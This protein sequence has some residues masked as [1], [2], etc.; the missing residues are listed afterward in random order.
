MRIA[1]CLSAA[2]VSLAVWTAVQCQ[3][4]ELPPKVVAF[5]RAR[6]KWLLE[7]II[8]E[9]PPFQ[10]TKLQTRVRDAL[11]DEEALLAE[12]KAQ[13]EPVL[14]R[15]EK[16]K[17]KP[18]LAALVKKDEAR[19]REFKD[20]VQASEERV[21]KLREKLPAEE[22]QA[23][24]SAKVTEKRSPKASMRPLDF[25]ALEVGAI[26]LLPPWPVGHG[27]RQIA[28]L[29]SADVLRECAAKLTDGNAFP[30]AYSWGNLKRA[31][32]HFGGL[33]VARDECNV[34]VVQVLDQSRVFATFTGSEVPDSWP[35]FVLDVGDTTDLADGATL[36]VAGPVKV[37]EAERY[38]TVGGKSPI[39]YVLKP[40]ATYAE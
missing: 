18:S 13:L 33:G 15:I 6:D 38:A 20:A 11:R 37:V 21:A 8:A 24:P 26:G 17:G 22:E 36:R 40:L 25:D 12:N 19:A 9:S 32:D 10:L 31:I 14:R 29:P 28:Y 7:K 4:D 3:A 23:A 2:L 30:G 1:K 16:N 35:L 39:R 5:F 27:L 34:R